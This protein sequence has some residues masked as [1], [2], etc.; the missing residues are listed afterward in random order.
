M[1]VNEPDSFYR[2]VGGSKARQGEFPWIAQLRVDGKHF[3]AGTIINENFILGAAHCAGPPEWATF[4]L[5][6]HVQNADDGME[7][8]AKV[9]EIIVHEN[10][11]QTTFTHDIALFRLT[12]PLTFSNPFIQPAR[13]AKKS[14]KP[15]KKMVVAG[16]GLTN[17]NN[18]EVSDIL[19]KATVA[20][21]PDSV[22]KQAYEPTRVKYVSDVQIC[23]GGEGKSSCKGDSGGPLHIGRNTVDYTVVGIVSFGKGCASNQY[24]AVYTKISAY[25]DWIEENIKGMN[26]GGKGEAGNPEKSIFIDLKS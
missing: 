3:C 9:A 25:V 21:R 1:L 2:I 5:G 24:P 16:W 14:T 22:C 8:V 18:T 6:E 11:N 12:R 15:S 17:Q 4:V 23:V 13:I 20:L 7:V 19:Q 26:Y 10:F